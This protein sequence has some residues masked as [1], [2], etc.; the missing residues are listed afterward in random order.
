[1]SLFALPHLLSRFLL[2]LFASLLPFIFS[3][4][5]VLCQQIRAVLLEGQQLAFTAEV[6][7]QLMAFHVP[8]IKV[9]NAFHCNRPNLI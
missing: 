4:C 8:H 7:W 2:L 9:A 6:H 1:M 3:F 5:Q